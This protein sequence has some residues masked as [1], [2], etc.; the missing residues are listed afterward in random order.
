LK[1]CIF[2]LLPLHTASSN[3]IRIPESKG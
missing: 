2:D 3:T 1:V